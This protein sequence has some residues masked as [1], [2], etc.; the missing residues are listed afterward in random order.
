MKKFL[1][2][3]LVLALIVGAVAAFMIFN[4]STSEVEKTIDESSTETSVENKNTEDELISGTDSMSALLGRGQNLECSITYNSGTSTTTPTT[5]TFFTSQGKV[6]GDYLI[7]DMGEEVVS[8]MIM[9]DEYLY[10]WTIVEGAKYGM[11]ISLADLE[12]SKKSEEAPKANEAVP[13]DADVTYEC[14]PWKSIDGSIFEPPADVLFKDYGELMNTG[15]EYGTVY[16]EGTSLK[17]NSPCALCEQV[18]GDG[19]AECK[20]A[21]SCE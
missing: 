19:K 6:R 4:N 2:I 8:S 21:F 10:S 7:P 12:A 11:K 20:A 1:L 9:N 3:G 14:K 18:E 16:D 17:G 13:L 5:G 15:M